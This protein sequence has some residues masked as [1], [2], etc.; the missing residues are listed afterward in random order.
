MSSNRDADVIVVGAGTGGLTTAAYLAAAGK[1]V[2]VVDRG[3]RPGGH[4]TVFE[5]GGYEFDI[6]LI[7]IDSGM[8]GRPAPDRLLAPLGIALQWN[9]IDSGGHGR[10]RRRQ[11]VRGAARH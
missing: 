5:R 1:Q 4:G 8:D 7:F 2:L 9:R 6:G 11:H 3:S 10:A